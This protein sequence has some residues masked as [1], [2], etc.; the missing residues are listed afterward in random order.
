MP[1]YN[2]EKQA[3]HIARLKNELSRISEQFEA[4]KKAMGLSQDESVSV[5]LSQVPE[6][7]VKAMAEVRERAE[8]DARNAVASMN[9]EITETSSGGNAGMRRARRGALLI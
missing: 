6:Q 7:V 4:T 3:E 1:K 8:A 5:D 9:M 2:I